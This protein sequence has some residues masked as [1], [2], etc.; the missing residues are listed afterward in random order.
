MTTKAELHEYRAGWRAGVFDAFN[1]EAA[2]MVAITLTTRYEY[3][4]AE[5][6][7]RVVRRRLD[8]TGCNGLV[9]VEEGRG[10][11]R[12]HAHGILVAGVEAE[13]FISDWKATQGFVVHEHITDLMGWTMYMFKAFGPESSWTWRKE[14]RSAHTGSGGKGIFGSSRR[15]EKG[16]AAEEAAQGILIEEVEAHD[17][18]ARQ[19]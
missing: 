5:G 1:H 10:D 19:A 7:N 3:Q 6:L 17:Q 16:P 9:L 4:K 14:G 15:A 12:L 2:E 11:G 18:E 13:R 8:S